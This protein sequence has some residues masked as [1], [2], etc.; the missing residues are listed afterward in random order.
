MKDLVSIS[1]LLT[2]DY[3]NKAH[4]TKISEEAYSTLSLPERFKQLCKLSSA[5]DL[6]LNYFKAKSKALIYDNLKSPIQS[7]AKM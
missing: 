5:L 1:C 3:Y 2:E 7:I 4:I 6:T